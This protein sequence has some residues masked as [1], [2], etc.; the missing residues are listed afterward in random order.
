MFEVAPWEVPSNNADFLTVQTVQLE[1]EEWELVL[2]RDQAR[3]NLCFRR[4]GGPILR[5]NRR[6]NK[7][8]PTPT[9]ERMKFRFIECLETGCWKRE[10]FLNRDFALR[11]LH[12]R[13][14]Y[15]LSLSPDGN[16]FI[17]AD[18]R[19]IPFRHAT[20]DVLGESG[21]QLIKRLE[22]EDDFR[23]ARRFVS[24]SYEEVWNEVWLWKRGNRQELQS[25]LTW[26]LRAPS[27]TDEL[28]LSVDLLDESLQG[29]YLFT[30]SPYVISGGTTHPLTPALRE[31]VEAAL[32][33]FAPHVNTQSVEAHSCLRQLVK[34]G[35]WV[36]QTQPQILSAH[37]RI[38]AALKWRD[39]LAQTKRP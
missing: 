27:G 7:R 33:W 36:I 31:A 37:E 12:E 5:D 29:T 34:P 15:S 11:T 17:Q 3:K 18:H 16:G 23:F 32:S 10:L 6:F 25:A 19:E 20:Q 4:I 30:P 22:D 21:Q 13:N 8:G 38:E 35:I 14:A 28:V 26:A 39:W 1:H 2:L 9:P 24:L